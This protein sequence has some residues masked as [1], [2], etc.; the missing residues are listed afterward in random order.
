MLT[1]WIVYINEF[2]SAQFA[3]IVYLSRLS[4]SSHLAAIMTLRKYF[5]EIQTLAVFRITIISLFAVLLSASISL[6]SAAFGPF[7]TKFHCISHY[8]PPKH[9]SLATQQAHALQLLV[10]NL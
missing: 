9:G 3:L 1:G 6:S 7:Y 8:L 4:S 10:L 5:E 2:D